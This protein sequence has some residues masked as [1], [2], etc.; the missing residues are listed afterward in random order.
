MFHHFEE[1]IYYRYIQLIKLIQ[2][3][4]CIYVICGVRGLEESSHL[5]RSRVR[6]EWSFAVIE[7]ERVNK[8]II[9]VSETNAI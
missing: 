1:L 2:L 3:I 9:V 7:V 6:G 5:W 4:G 8:D